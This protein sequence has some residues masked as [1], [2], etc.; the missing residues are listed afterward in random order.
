MHSRQVVQDYAGRRYFFGAI[1]R[2][3]CVS[4]RYDAM[5]LPLSDS[6]LTKWFRV[7]GLSKFKKD[8]A[9]L[10]DVA[11]DHEAVL[12]SLIRWFA[13]KDFFW[14]STHCGTLVEQSIKILAIQT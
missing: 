13:E 5:L 11:F 2:T 14:D 10:P 3:K 6:T 4:P 9:C 7:V 1:L 8:Y 12:D